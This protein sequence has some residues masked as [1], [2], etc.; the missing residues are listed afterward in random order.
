MASF[1]QLRPGRLCRVPLSDIAAPSSHPGLRAP[2]DTHAGSLYLL[3]NHIPAGCWPFPSPSFASRTGEQR[4]SISVQSPCAGRQVTRHL[5]A[6][7]SPGLCAKQM[8]EGLCRVVVRGNKEEE[9]GRKTG[10]GSTM[11]K[12][13]DICKRTDTAFFCLLICKPLEIGGLWGSLLQPF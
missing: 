13:I 5:S 3:C 11:N 12:T 2:V 7:P 4:V 10:R 9:K 1:S 8:R 6:F